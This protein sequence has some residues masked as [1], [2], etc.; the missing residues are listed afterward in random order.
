M[1]DPVLVHKMHAIDHFAVI[2]VIDSWEDIAEQ[3]RAKTIEI[4]QEFPGLVPAH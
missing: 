1:H 3:S 2:C 4:K